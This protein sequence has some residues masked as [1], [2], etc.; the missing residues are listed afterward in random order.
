MEMANKISQMRDIIGKK[1]IVGRFLIEPT[2][3]AMTTS[4]KNEAEVNVAPEKVLLVDYKIPTSKQ[5]AE[6][7]WETKYSRWDETGDLFVGIDKSKVVMFNTTDADG[8]SKAMFAEAEAVKDEINKCKNAFI[9]SGD[10]AAFHL[11]IRTYSKQCG[12]NTKDIVKQQS[13]RFM[14]FIQKRRKT[15]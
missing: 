3:M 2:T 7:M 15:G 6:G 10:Y 12:R 14:D 8:N 5:I 9:L 1:P 13:R 4:L 11:K